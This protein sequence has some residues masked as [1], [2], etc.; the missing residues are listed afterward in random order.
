MRLQKTN[1]PK[2]NEGFNAGFFFNYS[3]DLGSKQG[4]YP[5]VDFSADSTYQTIK[6]TPSIFK[7][8]KHH[9]ATVM[10]HN[11]VHNPFYEM[12]Q[13]YEIE[14]NN[15]KFVKV[16]SRN[17][18]T[19]ELVLCVKKEIRILTHLDH[20][21]LIKCECVFEDLNKVYMVCDTVKGVS[22]KSYII[23]K[24]N[25][26]EDECAVIAQQIVSILTYLHSKNIVLKNLSTE[27]LVFKLTE[28]S[29]AP[30]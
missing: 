24:G 2:I 22:L 27:N 26:E 1:G 30:K 29:L 11:G 25:L 8:G 9:K 12:R 15:S 21:N 7:V 20:P 19:P 3:F 16:F 5:I 4:Y 10:M 17:D 13:A 14:T 18:L 6:A 23:E 28:N